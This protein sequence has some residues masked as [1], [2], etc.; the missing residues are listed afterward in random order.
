MP[1]ATHEKQSNIIYRRKA[2]TPGKRP[3]SASMENNINNRGN[4]H[5]CDASQYDAD[6]EKHHLLP[7]V[8][9]H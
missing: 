8:T 3:N 9:L 5:R 7:I 1:V 6:G 2:L 4:Y